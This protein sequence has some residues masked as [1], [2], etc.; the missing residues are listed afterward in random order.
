MAALAGIEPN[1]QVMD[2]GCGVGGAAF[3][4]ANTFDCQVEGINL[5]N[6]QVELAKGFSKKTQFTKS[7][8][9]SGR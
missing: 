7:H 9:F 3:Y 5:S 1:N 6:R 4:L 8:P 2:A